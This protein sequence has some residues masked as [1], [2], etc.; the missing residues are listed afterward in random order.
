MWPDTTQLPTQQA[1]NLLAC[2]QLWSQGLKGAGTMRKSCISTW[3]GVIAQHLKMGW[4]HGRT[5]E[6]PLMTCRS[7]WCFPNTAWVL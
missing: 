7:E 6:E 1:G 4:C 3:S 5:A 2:R